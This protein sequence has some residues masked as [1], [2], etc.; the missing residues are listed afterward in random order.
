MI[1][2]THDSF[3]RMTSDG[4]KGLLISYNI[5]NL[6]QEVVK[7][8]STDM[9]TFRYLYDGTKEEVPE[10]GLNLLDFGARYYDPELC[11][12]TS[13]DPMAEKCYGMSP[14]GYCNNNP[15]YKIDPDGQKVRVYVQLNGLGHAFV[16]TGEGK[17]TKI[18][19]YGRYGSLDG[20]SNTN[21]T[22]GKYTPKGEGVL[23]IK[24]GEA[25][26]HYLKSVR[27]EGNVCMYIIP[28]AEDSRVDEY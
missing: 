14:Y 1:P 26:A 5:L 9:A 12:W 17:D 27:K 22:S 20:S 4:L 21:I 8:D 18:Y 19:S 24:T 11:R 15:I 23:L 6:P 16:S 28:D 2:F 3:A 10:G 25:A 13:V 7:T